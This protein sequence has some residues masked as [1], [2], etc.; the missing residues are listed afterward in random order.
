MS[1]S[2]HHYERLAKLSLRFAYF[3]YLD[4]PEYLADGLF[5]RHEVRVHFSSEFSRPGEQYRMITCKVRKR[6]L[7]R[8]LEAL[9]ELPNKMLLCGHSDYIDYCN[10]LWESLVQAKD[11]GRDS[12]EEAGSTQ[13]AKQTSAEGVS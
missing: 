2:C 10:Q 6:D 3:A 9:E 7:P 13:K 12:C 5:I 8:F 1:C 11:E 4:V